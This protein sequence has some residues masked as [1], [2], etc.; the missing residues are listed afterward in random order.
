MVAEHM[1]R[2][3]FVPSA[4]GKALSHIPSPRER[5]QQSREDSSLLLRCKMSGGVQVP[6]DLGAG[7]MEMLEI[8]CASTR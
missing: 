3:F 2:P 1:A 7:G 5:E 6:P 8:E 4:G